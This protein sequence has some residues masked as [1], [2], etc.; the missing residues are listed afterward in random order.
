MASFLPPKRVAKGQCPQCGKE[1]APYYLCFDCR[2]K[3]RFGRALTR[4]AKLGALKRVKQGRDYRYWIGDDKAE[5]K[6]GTAPFEGLPE[7]DRR[8]QPRLRGIRVDV[9]QTLVNVMRFIGRPCTLEEIQNAWG[10][11]RE[12]RASPLGNDLGHLIAAQDRRAARLAKRLAQF[13]SSEA[14]A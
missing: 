8:T 4:G 2:T 3:A 6:W 11:L 10:K 14:H 13:Q 7:T 12:R 9:E 5:G 1:S